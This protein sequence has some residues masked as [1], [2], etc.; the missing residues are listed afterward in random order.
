MD[1]T[2]N[3][4][5]DG[6]GFRAAG[7][8]IPLSLR[9][10]YSALSENPGLGDQLRQSALGAGAD[11]ADDFG[12]AQTADPAANGQR[13]P[14]GQAVEKPAGIEI[15]GAGGVDD[16]R[17]RCGFDPMLLAVG[18]DD[19]ALCAAG[20]RGDR[21]M[22]AHGGGGGGEVRGLV[23]R[24]DLDLVGEQDVDVAGDKVA[25]VGA[26][27]L[28]AERVGE[29]QRHLGAGGVGDRGGLAKRLLRQRRVKQIAFEI[30]DL[31]GADE[32]GVDVVRPELDAGAEIGVHRALA[33][34]GDKDQAARGGGAARRRGRVEPHA[35][36]RSGRGETPRPAGRRAPCR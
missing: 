22:A 11:M 13:Q 4:R 28:D 30:G 24:A 14:A 1:P 31:G 18:Q 2:Q 10:S 34:R 26:M 21:D 23:E 33:V 6:R 15:A 8:L 25:E 9:R 35:L 36:A 17:H 5:P 27:T 16:A 19:A 3:A 29:R 12:G 20:Q 32:A 7:S